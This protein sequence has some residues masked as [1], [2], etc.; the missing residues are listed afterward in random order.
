M[1]AASASASHGASSGGHAAGGHG[2]VSPEMLA[3][4]AR[5]LAMGRRSSWIFAV[6]FS[7]LILLFALFH[8]SRTLMHLQGNRRG[9]VGKAFVAPLRLYRSVFLR[10]IPKVTSGGHLL[11]ILT[12]FALNIAITFWDFTRKDFDFPY[13]MF[14]KR[15]GWMAVSNSA[16]AFLLAMKNSPIANLTGYSHE[17]LNVLHRWVGRTIFVYSQLHV[18]IYTAV[19]VKQRNLTK[20]Q[21]L[22]QV[23]GWVAFAAFNILWASSLQFIRRRFYEAFYM[24][25]IAMLII[26]VIMLALHKP[27]KFKEVMIAT[28]SFWIFDRVVRHAKQLYYS[29]NNTATLIP[30]SGMATKVVLSRKVHR[31]PGTHAFLSIPTIRGFQSHPFTISSCNDVEFVIKAQKGFTLDLHK[32]ALKNPNAKVRAFFDGPYGAVPDFR[33]F[34]KVVLFAG[35]SGGAFSFPIAM[36]IAMHAG[37]CNVTHVEFVWVIKDERHITWYEDEI[38]QLNDCPI[39]NVSIYVTSK[40]DPIVQSSPSNDEEVQNEKNLR[41]SMILETSQNGPNADGV[42]VTPVS[43]VSMDSSSSSSDISEPGSPSTMY[44]EKPLSADPEKDLAFLTPVVRSKRGRKDKKQD[45]LSMLLAQIDAVPARG[46]A[47]LSG[48]PNLTGIV[49]E[50][51]KS[52]EPMDSIMIGACGPVELMRVARNA[53]AENITV[54]GASISLHCEQFGWG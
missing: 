19:Y 18:Y 25:H 37:K 32:Y 33:R 40:T 43:P 10:K 31:N 29:Y 50:V 15:C 34:N 54:S 42:D 16:F 46:I 52:T 17:R 53:A 24:I 38:R 26:S 23:Y 14:N 39:V 2:A 36:D 28:G 44:N 22:E 9:T 45:R 13:T 47:T 35:G 20:L 8:F 11:L 3:A 7:G 30:L 48:R 41:Q 5:Q 51:V 21:D 12:Y 27:K 49:R 6:A 1:V 4:R